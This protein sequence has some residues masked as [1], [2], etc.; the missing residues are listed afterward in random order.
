MIMFSRLLD[1]ALVKLDIKDSSHQ[2]ASKAAFSQYP[3][4]L[5]PPPPQ[6]GTSSLCPRCLTLIMHFAYHFGDG[7]DYQP[8][9]ITHSSAIRDL[10]HAVD[11]NSSVA[12]TNVKECV[13]CVKVFILFKAM[14]G[15]V[16]FDDAWRGS[17]SEDWSLRWDASL[18]SYESGHENRLHVKFSV[19][20]KGGYEWGIGMY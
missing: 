9:S 16:S 10:S 19:T 2:T 5:F 8:L 12:R 6:G 13:I 1:K 3:T 14:Q 18:F 17:R 11:L 15:H 4:L 20:H 7:N